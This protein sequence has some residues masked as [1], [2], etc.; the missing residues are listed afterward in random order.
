[1]RGRFYPSSR[2]YEK[3]SDQFF[4]YFK[5]TKKVYI[6]FFNFTFY[7]K[8]KLTFDELADFFFFQDICK[9]IAFLALEIPAVTLICSGL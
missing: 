9:N 2:I 4:N 8:K 6:V 1:M 5:T 3:N 7:C